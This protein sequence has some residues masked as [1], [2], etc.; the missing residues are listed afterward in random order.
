MQPPRTRPIHAHGQ[1]ARR[2]GNLDVLDGLQLSRRPLEGEHTEIVLPN[3]FHR[4]LAH[5]RGRVA[6]PPLKKLA[7]IAIS[8]GHAKAL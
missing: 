5:R 7:D 8:P 3:G 1:H 2:T 4:Q 6:R